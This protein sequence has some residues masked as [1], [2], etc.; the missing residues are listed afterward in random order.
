MPA[1]PPA[2]APGTVP[3]TPALGKS[4]RKLLARIE[5]FCKRAGI[6]LP[7]VQDLRGRDLK[8]ADKVIRRLCKTAA[9]RAVALP[10]LSG[11]SLAD[12]KGLLVTVATN[13]A[14]GSAWM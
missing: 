14:G 8:E 10:D 6:D 5:T 12:L 1:V 11:R 3:A 13:P 7:A 2:D 4:D 9:K